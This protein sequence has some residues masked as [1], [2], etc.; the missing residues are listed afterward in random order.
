MPYTV[1]N[2]INKA[3]YLSGIVSRA[4]QSVTGEQVTDGL[5]LLNFIINDKAMDKAYIPY[6][7]MVTIPAVIG[8]E[9]YSIP[10]LIEGE[11]F[12]FNIGKLRYP[13]VSKSRGEYFA[14]GRFDGITSLPFSY[15][16]ERTIGGTDLYVYF[17]PADIYQFKVWGRFGFDEVTLNDD[18]KLTFDLYYIDYLRHE[19]AVSI[20]NFYKLSIPPQVASC[21]EA[22]RLKLRDESPPDLT[23]IKKSRLGG[24]SQLNYAYINLGN[25][26]T[27]PG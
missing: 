27:T 7:N 3:F 25:G 4:L 11:S 8:Q 26:W 20:C 10:N 2:L 5:E 9:K 12:T 22:M 23:M 18:L 19:L 14:S 15:H 21:L 1:V 6:F 16:F 17:V 13:C 24:K